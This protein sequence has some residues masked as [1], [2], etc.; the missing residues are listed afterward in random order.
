[1]PYTSPTSVHNSR[2]ATRR[3]KSREKATI[4][5]TDSHQRQNLAE[6]SR[7][8]PA[9]MPVSRGRQCCRIEN[10]AAVPPRGRTWHARAGVTTKS[11]E[12]ALTRAGGKVRKLWPGD[13][14]PEKIL[15]N[16]DALL[17]A[18]GGDLD[19]RLYGGT[20][21]TTELVDR[22]RD[23]FELALIRGALRRDM[24]ILGICRGIQILN[25]SQGG[26][27]RNLRDQ[28]KLARVH[29][30]TLHSMD[31]HPVEIA[32]ESK[33]AEILGAGRRDASSFHGQAIDRLGDG[34]RV[35]ARAPD[36]VVEAI[37]LPN[38]SF[39]IGLQWHPEL[40]PAQTE[41][42]EAFLNEA[43]AHRRRQ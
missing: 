31:A 27:V 17:L 18:G 10:L 24:P 9:G 22:R 16:I 3:G 32:A 41:L 26:T 30:I 20:P 36:G 4:S 42:F 23:D 2:V 8:R 37:E 6:A 28:P 34:L 12:I 43:K 5:K 14:N 11:Y 1:M 13:Q 39:V 25:V 19:P 38:R 40:P 35:S 7:L 29:S 15:D 21:G 33:L